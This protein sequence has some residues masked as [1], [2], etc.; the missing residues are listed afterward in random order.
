LRRVDIALLG[1]FIPATKQNDHLITALLEVNTIPRAMVDAQF[2]DALPHRLYI[3]CKVIGEPKDASSN[4]CLG[5]RITDFTLQ[6]SV[7]ISLFNIERKYSV[8]LRLQRL[9]PRKNAGF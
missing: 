5:T 9:N 3:T 1:A 4:Q 6:F 7:G 2:A 8:V